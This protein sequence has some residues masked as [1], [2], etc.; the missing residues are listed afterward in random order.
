MTAA[1]E[2]KKFLSPSLENYLK[3]ILNLQEK[4]AVARA[5]DIAKNL[6]INKSSVS[7][8]L[9]RLVEMDLV[10]HDAY[11]YATLT[12]KGEKLAKGVFKRYKTLTRFFEKVLFIPY[13]IAEENA[14]RMEHAI[15]DDVMYRLV[16][17]VEFMESCPKINTKWNEEFGF[18]CEYPEEKRDCERCI[19]A[20][21]ES[22]KKDE[23]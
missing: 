22:L 15:D 17:F 23:V 7:V 13:C 10:E 14:C 6:N 3:V 9:K 16:R 19:R 4:S 11:G 5:K 21:L 18:F 12:K 8:A 20:C 2:V 1:E